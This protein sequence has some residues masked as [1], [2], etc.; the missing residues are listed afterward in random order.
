M[1][2]LVSLLAAVVVFIAGWAVIKRYPTVIVLFAAGLIMIGLAI[3]FGAD[4]ILHKNAKTTGLIWFDAIDIIRLAAI[5]QW[6]DYYGC[7]WFCKIYGNHRRFWCACT[8][9]YF[10]AESS[11]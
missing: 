4:S 3:M 5:K 6:H 7:R 10:S 8:C 11:S 9:M 1:S 2:L